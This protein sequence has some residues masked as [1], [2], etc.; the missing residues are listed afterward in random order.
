M[1]TLKELLEARNKVVADQKALLALADKEGRDL[2]D[3]E[4]EKIGA[5]QAQFDALSKDID[6]RK[7]FEEQQRALET[8]ESTP[9]G[10]N[11]G[12]ERDL[13]VGD[14]REAKKPFASFG[15]QLRAIYQA[16]VRRDI[17]VDKRLLEVN[18]QWEARAKRAAP[19]GMHEGLGS[20]GG[21][22]LQTDFAGALMDTAVT[23]GQI[24]SRVDSYPVSAGSREVSW[25]DINETS[26]ATTVFGGVRVYWAAE[27]NS[28]TA[29]KPQLA[30]RKLVLEKLFGLA[31]ATSEMME[32]V[33]WLGALLSRA[34][35]TGIQR[36]LE[37]DIVLDG[38][39][40]GRPLSISNS[41]ALVSVAKETGQKAATVLY[42]NV[43]HA[44]GRMLPDSRANAVWLIH[45]DAEEVL[46]FMTIPV[47]TGGLPVWLPPGGASQTS[48]S[49]LFG[50]PVIPIDHCAAL[51]TVGDVIF[52]DL[53]QYLLANKGGVRE[54]VS[55]HVKFTTDEQTF[56]FIFRA[57]GR[58]KKTEALTIKNSSNKRSAFVAIATRA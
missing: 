10:L 51:G 4:G 12:D 45:P 41:G 47:G 40:T 6:R 44:W 52:A 50:R 13:E 30:E 17:P 48:F 27:A 28:V 15:E 25:M 53:N 57:N 35:S 18:S 8:P 19:S 21:F 54:D 26:V 46:P 31:Y 1:K 32:D 36:K 22:A 49:S 2:T 23:T 11:F 56:R 20:D 29:S 9:D 34:F 42:E 14:D 3:E 39:G 38:T 33:S 24:L 43:T 7:K 37:G 16:A 5:L 58:P 55:M